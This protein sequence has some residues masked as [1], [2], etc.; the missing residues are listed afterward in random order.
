ME[1][2][3]GEDVKTWLSQASIS[4]HRLEDLYNSTAP[5]LTEVESQLPMHEVTVM[6]LEPINYRIIKKEANAWDDYI[7]RPNGST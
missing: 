5:K 2:I 1:I 4:N 3:K 7:S 6:L